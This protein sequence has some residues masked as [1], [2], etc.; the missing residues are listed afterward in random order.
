MHL[1]T[2]QSCLRDSFVNENGRVEFLDRVMYIS[3]KWNLA[4]LD[5]RHKFRNKTVP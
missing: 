3:D 2:N 4:R 5:S 1:F